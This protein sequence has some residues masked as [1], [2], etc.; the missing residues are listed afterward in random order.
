MVPLGLAA[1][2]IAGAITLFL[3]HLAPVFGAGNFVK[4]LDEP[5]LFGRE[6]S[7][8]EAHLVG[9]LM[10]LLLNAAF[11]GMYAYLVV[12][13][14]FADFSLMPILG[15]GLLFTLFM[16]GV[17]T[18]IEGHGVFGVREDAWFPVDLI[19]AYAG[20]AIVFWWLIRLWLNYS[21]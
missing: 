19:L 12:A 2:V 17:V 10:H 1:G 14:V 6:I 8:R 18:P 13:G 21:F 20:W 11:G 7:R 4:D 5:Y 16:G 9:V 3:A 15:W